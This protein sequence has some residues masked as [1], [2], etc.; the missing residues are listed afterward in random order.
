MTTTKRVRA[1]TPA[2]M[3]Q[4][5]RVDT[6]MLAKDDGV[7]VTPIQFAGD[8][9]EVETVEQFDQDLASMTGLAWGILAVFVTLFGMAAGFLAG[10][11]FF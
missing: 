2:P 7:T 9:P 6:S 8:E 10:R 3:L 4:L 1:G 5:H 11:L